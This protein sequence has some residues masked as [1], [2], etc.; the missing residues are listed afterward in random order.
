[1]HKATRTSLSL[2]AVMTLLIGVIYPAIVWVLGQTI[3]P[4]EANGSLI[5]YKGRTV[6][7]ELVG[8]NFTGER[9]FWPRPSATTGKPYNALVSGASNLN[10]ANPAHVQ[11]VKDRIAVL[12]RAHDNKSGTIPADLVTASGSG[13]DPH[14]SLEGALY[15]SE[16]VAKARDLPL[17]QVRA[18]IDAN[19]AEKTL[20]LL[21]ERRV[22][23]LLLNIALDRQ[24]GGTP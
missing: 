10:P 22:N 20:G 23:V 19:T 17:K 16:R 7:S 21:G 5:S 8:Q 1:M 14:I 24:T 11:Q 12:S 9:Y 13:L 15:Q 2:L 18:L 6:G 3:F 4:H